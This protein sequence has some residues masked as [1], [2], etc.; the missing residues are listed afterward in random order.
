[1]TDFSP[2]LAGEIVDWMSQG[3]DMA[4]AP[5]SLWVTVFDSTDTELDG[6]LDGARAEV[7]TG[8]G[9]T[10]TNTAFEN[11]AEVSLGEATSDLTNVEDVAIYDSETLGN[12]LARYPIDSLDGSSV[13]PPFDVSQGTTLRFKAGDLSFDVQDTSDQ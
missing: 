3:S 7:S 1:M 9:W 10:R 11:A 6:D 5:S 8:S 2:H 4:T 12:Q 13:T